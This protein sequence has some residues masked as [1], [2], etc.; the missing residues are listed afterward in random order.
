M[1]IWRAHGATDT[2]FWCAEPSNNAINV[3]SCKSNFLKQALP[4]RAH[5]VPV[6]GA[7]VT[8]PPAMDHR[9]II[10]V[11]VVGCG[12]VGAFCALLLRSMGMRCLVIERDPDVCEYPRAVALD[13]DAARLLGLVSSQLSDWLQQHLLPCSI[14]IRNGSPCGA[15]PPRRLC[16]HPCC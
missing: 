10:D 9:E 2:F 12:P 15:Q 8:P 3:S 16:P 13:G 4:L 1:K 5:E 6:S 7:T 14:D 11:I